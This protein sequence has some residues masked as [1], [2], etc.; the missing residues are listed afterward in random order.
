LLNLSSNSKCQFKIS[1]QNNPLLDKQYQ[2]SIS[3]LQNLNVYLSNTFFV[4]GSGGGN[5]ESGTLP[6]NNISSFSTVYNASTYTY[7]PQFSFVGDVTVNLSGA[8]SNEL[9][10][11][12]FYIYLAENNNNIGAITLRNVGVGS[13]ESF[14]ESLI[15]KGINFNSSYSYK[16]NYV[17]ISQ[18]VNMRTLSLSELYTYWSINISNTF[19]QS[20]YYTDPTIYTQQN[21]PGD[22]GLFD[23][24]Y[25]IYGN[26]YSNRV[27]NK[28][29][30]VDYSNGTSI[31]TNFNLIMSSSAIYAQ[32]QPS[33]YTLKRHINP[34]YNGSKLYGST[35]NQYKTGDI[36]YANKPVIERYTDYV[37][38]YDYVQQGTSTSVIHILSL[39]DI[40]GNKI[41]LNGNTNFNF[42]ML[43]TIFPQS[44]SISLV[45][46][47]SNSAGL[48]TSGSARVSASLDENNIEIFGSLS[49]TDTGLVVPTNFNPYIDIYEIAKKA[50]LI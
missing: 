42:G 17:F 49:K 23:D 35:I 33:N 15:F 18:D 32:V 9:G 6:F 45:D 47:T 19:A 3:D 4:S 10:N 13:I 43:K 16:I 34:R 5:I 14:D 24:Y 29:F 27:S 8:W 21:F 39:V 28:Y 22:I 48:N 38:Q 31:P 26:V 11:A 36:S 41:A 37:A 30:D 7:T 46:L 12:V 1:L 2:Q 20:T 50:G 25:A 44:S 40:D